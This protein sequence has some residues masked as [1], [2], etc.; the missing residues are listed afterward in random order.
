MKHA[1][2]QVST[3]RR[4]ALRHHC[5]N[6]WWTPAAPRLLVCPDLLVCSTPGSYAWDRHGQ[7]AL[8]G[9]NGVESGRLSAVWAPY[10]SFLCRL[11]VRSDFNWLLL[12]RV[13]TR[14]VAPQLNRVAD[15]FDNR[16]LGA[17]QA[18]AEFGGR[19]IRLWL[20]CLCGAAHGGAQQ[21]QQAA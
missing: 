12:L 19:P 6:G 4:R 21:Q 17:F 10:R 8:T 11:R 16:V 15:L 20:R 7:Y 2:V 3:K 9:T 13:L 1:R 18:L 14:L 5:E